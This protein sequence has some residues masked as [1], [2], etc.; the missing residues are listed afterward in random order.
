MLILLNFCQISSL[1]N[2][3]HALYQY[4]DIKI[5]ENDQEKIYIEKT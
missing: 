3:W 1:Y 4:V 5:I 2:D